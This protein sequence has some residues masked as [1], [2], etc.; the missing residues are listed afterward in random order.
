MPDT[1]AIYASGGSYLK[2]EDLAD[3]D[4]I[5]LTIEGVEIKQFDDGTKKAVIS[6]GGT[7]KRLVVNK[8]NALMINEVAGSRDTD[9]W[10]GKQITLYGTK[11]EYGGKLTDGIRVR[12]PQRKGSGKKP[13]FLKQHD[14][15]NP[16]PAKEEDFD[17]PVPF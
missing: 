15:R 16:P 6:F 4:D 17:D 9:H 3:I 14:E 7:D 2:G 8:T 10:I 1:D 13:A 11:V 12:P 5:T